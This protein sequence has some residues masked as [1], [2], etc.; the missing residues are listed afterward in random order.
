MPK[1]PVDPYATTPVMDTP[2]LP[3]PPTAPT[4]MPPR[5]APIL[6]AHA[7]AAASSVAPQRPRPPPPPPPPAPASR[8][9]PTNTR[10]TQTN[11][12]GSG[13]TSRD[14]PIDLASESEDEVDQ[15][16]EILGENPAYGN[17]AGSSRGAS[18]SRPVAQPRRK[19]AR[20]TRE[21]SDEIIYVD[22]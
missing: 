17:L 15:S 14:A 22:D 1:G 19:R 13:F 8:K 6:R 5:V 9:R 2:S 3:A 11:G 4:R 20:Q 7:W 12:S 18:S 21:D 10:D 16:I